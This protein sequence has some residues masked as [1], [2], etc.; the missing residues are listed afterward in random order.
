VELVGRTGAIVLTGDLPHEAMEIESSNP[1]TSGWI[2][3][4]G[5][6][7]QRRVRSMMASRAL[8]KRGG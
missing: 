5:P 4:A 1:T 6:G 3:S 2:E 8:V 7:E